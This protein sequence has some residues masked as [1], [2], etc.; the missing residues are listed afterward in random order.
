V[1]G[2]NRQ[3]RK[4]RNG[5][6][7]DLHISQVLLRRMSGAGM[8]EMRNACTILV[9]SPEEGKQILIPRLKVCLEEDGV[10]RCGLD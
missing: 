5:D 2:R 6:L 9:R 10:G 3:M 1:A 8:G 4:E 7:Q